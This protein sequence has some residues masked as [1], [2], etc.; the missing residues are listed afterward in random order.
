MST[1]FYEIAR[2][3][4]YPL[5]E[6]SAR[7]SEFGLIANSALSLVPDKIAD[8]MRA[9]LP[10]QGENECLT[11]Q[12]PKVKRVKKAKA[13]PKPKVEKEIK[14]V[15][16][17]EVIIEN[18]Q[19]DY[20][21]IDNNSDVPLEELDVSS[22]SE[23]IEEIK[24]VDAP[25]GVGAELSKNETEELNQLRG[26]KK[27]S[28]EDKLR[29]EELLL[30]RIHQQGSDD[31]G[32][33]SFA[34][35]RI[36]SESPNANKETP[37]K[38]RKR[39]NVG[40]QSER[41]E[42]WNQKIGNMTTQSLPRKVQN[43]TKGSKLQ[44]MQLVYGHEI[45]KK[46]R[47]RSSVRTNSGESK[48]KVVKVPISI[49]DLSEE[50]GIKANDAIKY[51][52]TQGLFLTITDTVDKEMAESLALEFNV[53]IEFADNLDEQEVIKEIIKQSDKD[54]DLQT[55]PPIITIM[56]HVDHGKTTLL[57]TIRKSKVADGESGGITQHIGGY[58]VE[59]NGN[60]MTFLDT[61][62]HAAFTSMRA[63]GAQITDIVILVVAANDGM[64]PQ[65]EEAINHAK[66]AGVPIIVAMNKMDLA[67][68]DPNKIKEQLAALDL[69]PEEWSGNT[70][71]VPVSAL[72]GDGIKELLEMINLQTEMLEL[73]ADFK[74]L[75]E[76]IVIESHLETGR[77]VVA[78]VLVR[79]GYL[80]KGDP[81]LCGKGYGFLR[82]M[83]DENSKVVKKAGPSKIVKLMGL[84]TCPIP[85][86][87]FNIMPN[88]K[89]AKEM[90]AERTDKDRDIRLKEKEALTMDS[91]MSQLTEKD[92]K[93]TNVIIKGD[94]QGS[95][96]ALK[97]ALGEL[98]N[99][100][101]KAKIVHSG[102]GAVSESDVLLAK[103]SGSFILAFNV[104]A[105]G[106]A[107][108]LAND[109]KIEIHKYSIIYEL[110]EYVQS[111]LEGM[112][113]P[114]QIEEAIGEVEVREVFRITNIGNIAGSFVKS[115]YVERNMQVRLIRDG[116]VIYN[117]KIQALR[118]FKDDVK[119]V[120]QKYE[121]GIRLENYEDIRVNDIV[122]TFK[123]TEVQKKL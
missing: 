79:Q 13:K 117:G 63:R 1:R 121:C 107:K 81:V 46:F 4:N 119:R 9:G 47:S 3:L 67:D 83:E 58:Q 5:E 110:I 16:E 77:G 82:S 14:K 18:Q 87:F 103:T 118:R 122:E 21:A 84:S 2:D 73:K 44:R 69:I 38:Q 48:D 36:V 22:N 112:L 100:E 88:I 33:D 85:G 25:S 86:E 89:K 30:G 65:T 8:K 31:T 19:I 91:L 111:H 76:G 114:D 61:P 68:A 96:E 105:D 95:V 72:K 29:E 17:A 45:P 109:E 15:M 37:K 35:G 43:E 93:N 49:R 10:Q 24:D 97:Q 64:M 26:K 106:K 62:G 113:E 28:K 40:E 56:G 39:R 90:A 52:M 120:E 12:K 99:E 70:A 6:I 11:K 50:I 75:G 55:R 115:G 123:I 42:Q 53:E 32:E 104:T 102:I 23:I 94:V 20:G 7:A 60:V 34:V 116:K 27:K 41:I 80:K 66:Q 78:N 98:G 57:D 54:E 71:Y 108:R 51:L 59:S 92:V 101:V 74:C